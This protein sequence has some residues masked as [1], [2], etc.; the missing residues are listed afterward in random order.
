M[1]LHRV[2]LWEGFNVSAKIRMI[3]I[4]IRSYRSRLSIKSNANHSNL[5]KSH[6][7]PDFK[8]FVYIFN[9]THFYENMTHKDIKVQNT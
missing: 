9:A 7:V 4:S 8:R 6:E 2:L 5:S 3:K 1:G